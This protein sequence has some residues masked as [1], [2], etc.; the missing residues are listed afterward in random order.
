MLVGLVVAQWL[1]SNE[2]GRT[3]RNITQF[4]ASSVPISP[5]LHLLL[6]LVV[7]ELPKFEAYSYRDLTF[8]Y[9]DQRTSRA[10]DKKCQSLAR[11][12]SLRCQRAC[13]STEDKKSVGTP[14]AR[15]HV[16]QGEKFEASWLSLI[17]EAASHSWIKKTYVVYGNKF[18]LVL[19]HHD[20]IFGVSI[21]RVLP[22]INGYLHGLGTV[23]FW[24]MKY[25]TPRSVLVAAEAL[26]S[27]A[28]RVVNVR[29]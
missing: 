6:C 14:M 18:S 12:Q 11:H 2:R 23:F 21:I 24:H 9:E 25:A 19:K 10:E 4:S 29:I 7:V 8:R 15:Q 5:Y 13:H 22:I 3:C 28:G 20:L 17:F 16:A 27:D 26:L 1:A